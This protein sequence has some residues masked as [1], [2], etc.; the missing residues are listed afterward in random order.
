MVKNV[1]EHLFNQFL[2]VVSGGLSY[3]EYGQETYSSVV[4]TSGTAR[5][6]PLREREV[7]T[8]DTTIVSTT[9]AFVRPTFSGTVGSFA[10]TGGQRFRINEVREHYD[11]RGIIRLKSL[12]LGEVGE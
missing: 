10:E 2:T 11:G 3:D 12:M 7:D 9:R 4:L 6:E 5:I 1:P 8:A